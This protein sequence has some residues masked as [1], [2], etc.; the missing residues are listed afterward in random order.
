MKKKTSY[1]FDSELGI[2]FKN[3][4]GDISVD[5]IRETWLEAFEEGLV[6]PEANGFVLDYREARFSFPI[7]SFKAI[8]DF[9]RENIERFRNKRIA[10]ITDKPSDIVIPILVKSLDD[11]Y[12]PREFTTRDAAIEWV[13]GNG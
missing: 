10:I 6:P 11:G 1:N 12:S 4:Y 7:E 2:V 3:Y 5:D 9:Y 8:P 13:L